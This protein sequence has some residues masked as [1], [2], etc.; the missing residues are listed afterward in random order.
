MSELAKYLNRH[1][2]GNVFG[3]TSIRE[4]YATDRSIL[5]E[6]PR[7]VALPENLDD[8][9]KLVRFSNQ[10]ASK[11]FRLPVTVRGT[12]LDKTGAAIGDGLLISLKNLIILR[13]LTHAVV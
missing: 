7:V 6:T 3:K 13:K 12:G 9:R 2:V 4:A 1:I 11:G 8:V 5:H 10:L